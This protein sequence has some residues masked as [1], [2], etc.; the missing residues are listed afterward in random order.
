MNQA[1]ELAETNKKNM[2]ARVEAI[3]ELIQSGV[4]DDPGLTGPQ[5]PMDLMAN[6]ADLL[7]AE[8]ELESLLKDQDAPD[9]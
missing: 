6:T 7:E 2:Q 8:R 1:L 3:S 5:D 4:L 9:S